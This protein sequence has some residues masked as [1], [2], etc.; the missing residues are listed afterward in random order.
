MTTVNQGMSVE[1]IER[2]VAQRVVNAIEAIAIY[3]MKTNIARKS[4]IQTERQEDKVAEN[5]SNKRKWK[6]NHNGSSSQQNKGHKVPRAHTTWPINKKAYAGS[7]P[8]CNQCKFHHN[9]PC[10]VI[11]ARVTTRETEDKSKEKQLEDVPT[12]RDFPD[13]F[14]EDL[15]GLPRTR[16]VEISDQSG[17]WCCICSAGALLINAVRNEKVVRAT[18]RTIQQRLIKTQFLTLGSSGL[19][20]QVEGWIVSNEH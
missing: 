14:P 12:I 3:E 10:T 17:T 4:M 16:Q 7:L 11:L 2:V 19:V 5:A 6:G 18:A 1:E 8:L 13:V 20:S 15:P 9:G